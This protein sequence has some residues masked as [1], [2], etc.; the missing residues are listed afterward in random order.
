[1][2]TAVLKL[3]YLG[4]QDSSAYKHPDCTGVASLSAISVG[5]CSQTAT[6]GLSL[7]LSI[8]FSCIHLKCTGYLPVLYALEYCI[9]SFDMLGCS[10]NL[11]DL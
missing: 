5:N 3:F 2:Y 8:V 1:M 9:I 4:E 6:Q 7:F 11:L 10:L